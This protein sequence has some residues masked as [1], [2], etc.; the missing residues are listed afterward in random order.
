MLNKIE[1][2][3][4]QVKRI[5]NMEKMNYQDVIGKKLIITQVVVVTTNN[6]WNFGK[7]EDGTE[8]VFPIHNG[9][10]K[11]KVEVKEGETITIKSARVMDPN[12]DKRYLVLWNV[13]F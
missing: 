1:P 8:V 12:V 9:Q 7:F 11:I 3:A 5:K 10:R 13:K 2:H 6:R 4:V